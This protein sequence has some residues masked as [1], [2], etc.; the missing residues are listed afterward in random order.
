[1]TG[2]LNNSVAILA[3]EAPVITFVTLLQFVTLK[4]LVKQFDAPVTCTFVT[5]L[6]STQQCSV[7]AVAQY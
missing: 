1:M 6:R 7:A 2:Q 3:F 5:N 4:T